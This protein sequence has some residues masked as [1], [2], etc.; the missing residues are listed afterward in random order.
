MFAH[1]AHS[2]QR[3]HH[4][5]AVVVAN[6]KDVDALAEKYDVEAADLSSMLLS[7]YILNGC[8]TMSCLDRGGKRQTYKTAIDYLEDLLP[9]CRY[10]DPGGKPG[11]W[12][13]CC[14]MSCLVFRKEPPPGKDQ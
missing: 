3:L 14:D 7:P 5:W 10:G 6:D 13:R 8:D 4:K 11:C 2:V 9:L 12:R 1:I